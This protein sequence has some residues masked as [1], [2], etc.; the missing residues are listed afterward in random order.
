M[1]TKIGYAT[2]TCS[3]CGKTM[4]QKRPADTAVCSCYRVCPLCG[5][6]M[7]PFYADLNAKTYGSQQSAALKGQAV[8]S[9]EW[10]VET[11]YVCNNHSPPY[12]SSQKPVEVK[13][14]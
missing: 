10:S 14:S 5:A 11:V 13:M 7:T 9:S 12:Y 8:E 2:G 3:R 4:H 6:E 1:T